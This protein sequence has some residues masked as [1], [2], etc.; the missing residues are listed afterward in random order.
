MTLKKRRISLFIGAIGI[1]LFVFSCKKQEQPIPD[2]CPELPTNPPVTGPVPKPPFNPTYYTL[3]APKYFPPFP[4]SVNTRL[5]QEAV[6]LGRKLFYEKRLSGDNTQSCGSCHNQQFAFSD[7]GNQFS[8]G[9]DGKKGNMNAMALVNLGW[10]NG[11]FWD[12]RSPSL[13]NQAIEPVLNPIEMHSTWA[14]GLN[15]LKGDDNYVKMFWAAFGIEDFDSTHAATA[16]TQFELTLLSANSAYDEAVDKI[17][18]D[19][20]IPPLFSDPAVARGYRIF[21]TEPSP[22]G[23]GGDCFHCHNPD[24]LLFTNNV[25]INNGLDVSPDPGY[26]GVTGKETDRGK[27][28]TPT[29]RNIQYSAPYM[30]DGRFDSLQE[31]VEFYNSGVN[32]NSP[33]ISAFMDKPGRTTGLNLKTQ[34]KRDLV[35]FLKALSDPTF[36]SKEEFKDPN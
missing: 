36:L 10:G 16:I 33:N 26:F 12:G 1:F 15:K 5:S 14:V 7:N 13:E 17:Q 3:A 28:K 31:V 4:S 6:Q 23:G 35:T 29:L 21:T 25:F 34:E 11:F 27:F 20:R 9:I 19:P 30:H 2:D 22:N 8:T 24:N 32:F 18:N